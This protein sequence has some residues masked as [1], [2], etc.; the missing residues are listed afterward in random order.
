MPRT[1][2]LLDVAILAIPVVIMLL[3]LVR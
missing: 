2:D 1:A 3:S